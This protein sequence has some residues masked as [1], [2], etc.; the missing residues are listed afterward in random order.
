MRVTFSLRNPSS[1][2]ETAINAFVNFDARRKL[3]LATG[4]SILP[5]NWNQSKRRVKHSA[6]NAAMINANLAKI[7]ADV[8]RIAGALRAKG[9][10]VTPERFRTAWDAE[11]APS[12]PSIAFDALYGLYIE[13][14]GDRRQ[15][16]TVQIHETARNHLRE[17]AKAYGVRLDL[18]RFD[19]LLFDKLLH[20]LNNVVRQSNATAWKVIRTI[21]VFLRWAVDHGYTT[22]RDFEQ[23]TQRRIPKGETS[24]KVYL[25]VAELAAIRKL[26]LRGDERLK[27]TRDLLLFQCY[28][29]LRW[30]DVQRVGPE[31]RAGDELQLV[32]AKNRKN[33]R[34]PL[35]GD[36]GEILSRWGGRL[37]RR[38]NQKQNVA[39]KDLCRAA[40]IG[41]TVQVVTYRGVQRVECAAAKCDLIGTHSLKRTFV[42]LLRQEG[43]SVET[44][45]RLTGN[46]RA[47]IEGY[48][49]KDETDMRAEIDAAFTALTKS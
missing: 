34:I 17:F 6:T 40:G 26:D 38:S 23:F 16:S 36:A 25:T 10:L 19:A 1:D 15:R 33:V 49:L 22:C 37:P 30:S 39:L 46:T 31:H 43:V 45:C 8:L 47:T 7:E 5:K 3:K 4:E 9:E 48:I 13:S 29:G 18:E 28:T 11:R 2:R 14:V 24:D 41:R 32:T 44:I 20:Y 27:V 12:T 42:S 21:R 35:F